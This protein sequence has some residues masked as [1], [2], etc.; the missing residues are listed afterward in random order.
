M[1]K[2]ASDGIIDTKK[3]A[4]V[5]IFL[6]HYLKVNLF[7]SLKRNIVNGKFDQMIYSVMDEW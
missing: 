2:P 7:F 4:H 6:I 3:P 5:S 1:T